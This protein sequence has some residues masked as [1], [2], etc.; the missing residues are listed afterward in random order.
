SDLEARQRHLAGAQAAAIGQPPLDQQDLEAGAGE[1]GAEDEAV[2][3]GADDDAVV[4]FL[5]RLAQWA[6]PCCFAGAAQCR[7]GGRPVNAARRM[8]PRGG[9]MASGA[10]I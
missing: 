5:Q 1:I 3:T 4:G 8:G 9:V 6:V 7:R 2:M 10:E